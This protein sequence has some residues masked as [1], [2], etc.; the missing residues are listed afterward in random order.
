MQNHADMT[1]GFWPATFDLVGVE[2]RADLRCWALF[3]RRIRLGG[4]V[5]ACFLDFAHYT[6]LRRRCQSVRSADL[7]QSL[8]ATVTGPWISVFMITRCS[9]GCPDQST[10]RIAQSNIADKH[11]QSACVTPEDVDVMVT[12]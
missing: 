12:S 11:T 8:A 6:L 9:T 10:G 1:P 5:S 3:K 4:H 7:P 2:P